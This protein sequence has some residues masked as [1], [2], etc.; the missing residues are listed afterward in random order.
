MQSTKVLQRAYP[1]NK[2]EGEITL[3]ASIH[4]LRQWPY[5]SKI[6]GTG[7]A[8]RNLPIIN[9]AHGLWL[10]KKYIP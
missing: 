1:D 10:L 2:N 3:H 7:P 8:Y 4:Y 5:H 9:Y 6:A